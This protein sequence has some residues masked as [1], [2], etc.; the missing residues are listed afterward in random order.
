SIP[1]E[2]SVFE[3]SDYVGGRSTTVDAY[4][5]AD[6]PIELGASI[7]V[8]VNSN[9]VQATKELGL[10]VAGMESMR[11]GKQDKDDREFSADFAVYNGD[12]FVFTMPYID[13]KKDAWW[14]NLKVLWRY[15]M[16]PIYTQRLMK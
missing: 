13:N 2:I 9:L 14:N 10:E 12:E 6:Y 1:V 15:G 8:E 5:D 16:A 4:G 3:R 7:F 11:L